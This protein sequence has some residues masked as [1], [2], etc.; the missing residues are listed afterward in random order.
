[1]LLLGL[2]SSK[3]DLQGTTI[4]LI[5][6]SFQ[7]C[8]PDSRLVPSSWHLNSSSSLGLDKQALILHILLQEF[9]CKLHR[10]S[11]H[12]A[13]QL[14]ILPGPCAILMQYSLTP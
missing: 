8:R 1:M 6:A 2:Y 5:G 10:A 11:D 13:R 4:V 7:Q 9:S 14:F 3:L 12:I